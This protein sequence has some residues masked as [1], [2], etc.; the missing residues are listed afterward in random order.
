[1]Y[2]FPLFLSDLAFLFFSNFFL[3]SQNLPRVPSLK[4]TN[5]ILQITSAKPLYSGKTYIEGRLSHANPQ[6]AAAL[7]MVGPGNFAA[8]GDRR[9]LAVQQMSD[10][11]YRIYAGIEEPESLTRPGGT[12]DFVSDVDKSRAALLDL[13]AGWAPHLRAFIEQVEGPWRAWPLYQ[14]DAD[15]FLEGGGWNHVP[16]VTLLGDAAHVAL[17]NGEGVNIA[18]LDALKLFEYLSAEL[19]TGERHGSLD[20]AADTAAIERAIVAYESD[21]RVRA[22]EHIL[23]GIAMNDMM[24]KADGAQRMIAM[25]NQFVTGDGQPSEAA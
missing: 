16:G 2:S 1:M 3:L 12:L 17:P 15:M 11:T 23:D 5:P 22:R 19:G 14:L 4:H 25:F 9:M 10:R 13:F 7:E 8:I 6:Y 21:M 20:S 24:Y 18:M